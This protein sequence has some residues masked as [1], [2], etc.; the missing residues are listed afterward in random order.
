METILIQSNY[1]FGGGLRWNSKASIARLTF[2]IIT[3]SF[4]WV[5]GFVSFYVSLLVCDDAIVFDFCL[6]PNLCCVNLMSSY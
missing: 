5:E 1:R 6:T 3:P 2:G 4:V